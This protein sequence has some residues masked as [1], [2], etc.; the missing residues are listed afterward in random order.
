MNYE[1]MSNADVFDDFRKSGYISFMDYMND[2]YYEEEGDE[3]D[4]EE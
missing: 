3:D 2:Y 1:D 4:Y